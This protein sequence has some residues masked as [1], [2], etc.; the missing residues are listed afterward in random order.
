[1]WDKAV[2]RD[3]VINVRKRPSHE[4]ATTSP[5]DAPPQNSFRDLAR[6]VI[7]SFLSANPGA[8]KDRVYDHLVGFMFQKGRLEQHN[9]DKLLDSVAERV[10]DGSRGWVLKSEAREDPES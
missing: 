3:L 1:V 5:A 4:S 7:S 6:E 2:K 9:F 8:T 10:R